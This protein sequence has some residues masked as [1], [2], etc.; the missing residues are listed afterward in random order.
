MTNV[1]FM[2]NANNRVIMSAL[3]LPREF[4]VTY[5]QGELMRLM[6]N[7]TIVEFDIYC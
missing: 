2:V 3:G 5:E 7:R 6:L 4:H 1:Q